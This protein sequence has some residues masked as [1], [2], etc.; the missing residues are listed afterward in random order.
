[1]A[2]ASPSS[3]TSTD[4]TT[5]KCRKCRVLL[6]EHPPHKILDITDASDSQESSN[7]YNICDENLPQW[8]N[9]AVE[10]GSWTKGKLS[11]P[12]CSCRVGGFDYVSGSSL[13]VY[14]VRSKVDHKV[15][16]TEGV[17]ANLSQPKPRDVSAGAISETAT[18]SGSSKIGSDNGSQDTSSGDSDIISS[19]DESNTESDHAEDASR[20]SSSD[21]E[22]ILRSKKQKEKMRKRR[23]RKEK[24][25]KERLREKIVKKENEKKEA[26]LKELLEGEPELSELG[27]DVIC[28]VCLDLLH[29]PFQVEPCGHI[30][31][32]PCLRRLGQ[33]NPMNCTCP[34]C[35]TKIGFCKHLAA[36]SRE[37]REEHEGLY[38]KRKK[39]ERSTPVF[40]YPLPWQPGWR[41]LIRGRPLGGNRFLV[42]DNRAEYMRAILHQI[43]YYIPP[44]MIA[45]L[46]NIGIFAFMMGFIEVFPNLLAI[47]FGS[48]KNISL[49]LNATEISE[50]SGDILPTDADSERSL[51]GEEISD[52]V[53][54]T[55]LEEFASPVLDTTFYY[56]LFALSVMAA[57]LGQFLLNHELHGDYGLWPLRI[58]R[59]TDMFFVI[60]LTVLPLMLI[61][62]ILPFRSADGTWFGNF[63]E[64]A[65]HFLFNHLNYHTAILLCF[66]VWFI[67]HVDVNEDVLW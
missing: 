27:D 67:Y 60:V 51:P 6:L 14:I 55:N 19:D 32:E 13:P 53:S 39:F 12:S 41:N 45:N 25:F 20:E 33:K 8:I 58:N 22:I 48:G 62:T 11:C 7:V 52:E 37:I 61:P 56:I 38:L 64:K 18:S 40:S 21:E 2:L 46:I 10:E 63:I 9:D 50:T 23:R 26:K 44:V 5:L 59:M 24:M 15:P 49:P 66:T 35:R 57:A 17:L 3:T 65:I 34:L 4:C 54:V 36:T 28:P 47:V 30:F 43:P 42:R 1:M 29:E 31:C 16:G